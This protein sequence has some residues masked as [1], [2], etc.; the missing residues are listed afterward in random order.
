MAAT[1][2]GWLSPLVLGPM[3]GESC[4]CGY[5]FFGGGDPR[6]FRP[7]ENGTHCAE[8]YAWVRDCMRWDAHEAAGVVS[9]PEKSISAIGNGVCVD[10]SAYGLGTYRCANCAQ[11]GSGKP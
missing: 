6:L 10:G 7:D 1:L 9:L 5:G 4:F 11:K 2:P 8:W 3:D